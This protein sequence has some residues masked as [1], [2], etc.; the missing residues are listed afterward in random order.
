MNSA[1]IDFQRFT[2]IGK[3][4]TVSFIKKVHIQYSY[5]FLEKRQIKIPCA[6]FVSELQGLRYITGNFNGQFLKTKS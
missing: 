2:A 1:A 3:S 5:R 6:L 4:I